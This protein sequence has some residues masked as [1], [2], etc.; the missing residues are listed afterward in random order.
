MTADQ[1]AAKTV[2]KKKKKKKTELESPQHE[3]RKIVEKAV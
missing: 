2:V 3:I 1:K